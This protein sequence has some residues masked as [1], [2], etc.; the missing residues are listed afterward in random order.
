MLPNGENENLPPLIVIVGPTAVGKTGISLKLALRFGGEVVSADSRLI[1]KGLDIG[2]DKPSIEERELVP[3]HLIDICLPD[4]TIGLGQYKR[5]ATKAIDGIHKTGRL[6]LLV[7]GTGQYVKAVVEGW[8]VPEVPPN[9]ELRNALAALGGGELA[10]WLTT[11]D[12]V[13]AQRIDPRN[14]RR[15]VRALEVILTAG[16]PF[17]TLQSRKAP[18]YLIKIIGLNC[19]REVLYQRINRRVD[20]M[21][22][23]GLL[24]EVARLRDAGYERMLPSM[25]ALGYRQLWAHLEGECT[26]DEAVS[27]VK[28]E[29]HRFV[30]QQY[31]WLRRYHLPVSWFEVTEVGW[32]TKVE[33]TIDRWL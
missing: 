29:T 30:R 3:H 16:R 33:D 28:F 22:N 10:R 11:L 17:S 15:V 19:E 4:E 1:Y 5:L 14:V 31:T 8:N 9:Q 24:S 21:M 27:R 26:L 23:S 7:G 13:A 2:T 6:P 32:E 20:Q 18:P 25:S 12:P